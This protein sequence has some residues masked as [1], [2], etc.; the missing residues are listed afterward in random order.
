MEAPFRLCSQRRFRLLF[1]PQEA[2]L[3]ASF[4]PFTTLFKRRSQRLD[5]TNEALLAGDAGS[6]RAPVRLFLPVD[7]GSSKAWSAAGVG[8]LPP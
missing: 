4:T 6:W 5:V 2:P 1:S 8:R 7:A 3:E